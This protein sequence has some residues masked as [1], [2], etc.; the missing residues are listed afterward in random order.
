MTR[1]IPGLILLLTLVLFQSAIASDVGELRYLGRQI[2]PTGTQA[3]GTTV[4]GLSGID[5]DPVS[6]TYWVLSDDRSQ[7]QPAR[8]YNLSLDLS[9]FNKDP[10][11]GMTGVTFHSVTFLMQPDGTPFPKKEADPAHTVDPESIR[12]HQPTGGLYWTSEGD[13]SV[14]V[15]PFVREMK[16]DGRAVRELNL[17]AKYKPRSA[18]DKTRGVRDNLSLES[19]AF[20]I[21]GT[22]LYTAP[23]NALYQDGPKA[24]SGGV[25]MVRVAVFDVATGQPEAEFAYPVEPVAS[26][27]VPA[28]SSATNGLSEM[29]AVDEGS[30]IMVERAY[31]PPGGVKVRL[32]LAGLDGATD[33]SGRS[34]LKEGGYTPMTKRL[35]LDLGTLGI[36]PD[37]IE[38]M[39][40]GKPLKNGHRTLILVS[41][42][43]FNFFQVTQFLAFEVIP[44]SE[45]GP[46]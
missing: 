17:L 22:R 27:P 8:F 9:G 10:S 13:M 37:N 14:P 40:F 38:G 21:D 25:S 3:F 7:R 6:N 18:S 23:E 19:L 15:A 44:G 20:S 43:N 42:N 29:L 5:Y 11:P 36:S 24:S 39:T 34:S 4:G 1:R 46:E 31:S 28:G 16:T 32:Y 2:V 41:D 45:I 33:V 12:L 26:K 35:L 30:F